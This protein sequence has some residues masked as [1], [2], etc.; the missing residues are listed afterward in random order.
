MAGIVGHYNSIPRIKTLRSNKVIPPVAG[1]NP[2]DLGY[3]ELPNVRGQV[4]FTIIASDDPVGISASFSVTG[5][6]GS[7]PDD[8]T[9]NWYFDRNTNI[10]CTVTSPLQNTLD[11]TTNLS[12]FGGTDRQYTIIFNSGQSYAPQI[13]QT[14][15]SIIGPN[16]L[17]VS[18]V[19]QL[20]VQGF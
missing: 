8:P 10:R 13:S 7:W 1:I 3:I 20:V 12:A 16:T 17:T 5:G 9:Q 11:I 4:S 6:F 15:V 18:M 2:V 14:S 19:K